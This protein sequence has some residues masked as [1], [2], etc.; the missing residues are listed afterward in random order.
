[1]MHAKWMC[2]A[3][4]QGTRTIETF[5]K[6]KKYYCLSINLSIK[7]THTHKEAVSN[8]EFTVTK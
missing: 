1:M 7:K 5:I 3:L 6:Y 8:V 2:H 4:T